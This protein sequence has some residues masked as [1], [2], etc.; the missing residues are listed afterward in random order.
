MKTIGMVVGNILLV[1]LIYW[2]F[3]IGDEYVDS[4]PEH[5]IG[6]W[7]LN[8]FEGR[9]G[10]FRDAYRKQMNKEVPI[11]IFKIRPEKFFDG[12]D[13]HPINLKRLRKS[14]RNEYMLY[15]QGEDNGFRVRVMDKTNKKWKIAEGNLSL[16]RFGHVSGP[17]DAKEGIWEDRGLFKKIR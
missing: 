7:K 16:D 3:T 4:I 13:W 1:L 5:L 6:D 17:T 14:H 8:D 2:Y 12:Y 9:P 10:H 11:T 15:I